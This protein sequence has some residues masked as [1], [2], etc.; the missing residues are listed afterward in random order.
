VEGVW[1]TGRFPQLG[2]RRL[3]GVRPRDDP[4]KILSALLIV[5]G[6]AVFVRTAVAGGGVLALGYVLGVLLVL[7]GALR[8]YLSAR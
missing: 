6:L 2:R 7:A 3:G 4:V 5:L 1:G 8:L